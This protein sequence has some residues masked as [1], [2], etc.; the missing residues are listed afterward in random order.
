MSILRNA[1]FGVPDTRR[2]TLSILTAILPQTVVLDAA[3][4]DALALVLAVAATKFV[5]AAMT[6]M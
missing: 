1:G 4:M 2:I 3:T 6:G 5:A